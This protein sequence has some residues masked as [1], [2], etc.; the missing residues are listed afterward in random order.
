MTKEKVN[1]MNIKCLQLHLTNVRETRWNFPTI[2]LTFQVNIESKTIRDNKI[3]KELMMRI[4]RKIN[5]DPMRKYL[6]ILRKLN[7]PCLMGKLRR[8]KR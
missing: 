5:T 1:N 6:G 7:E 3:Q 8:E 4:K 2:N